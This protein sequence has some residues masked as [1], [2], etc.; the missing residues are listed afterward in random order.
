VVA[1]ARLRPIW[2]LV[3]MT[4]A[5]LIGWLT[6]GPVFWLVWRLAHR[7]AKA[8]ADVVA[9]A[10]VPG[11]QVVAAWYV[12]LAVAVLATLALT[13]NA[14]WL[15]VV[16]LLLL[17]TQLPTAADVAVAWRDGWRGRALVWRVRRWPAAR[18]AE[19]VRVAEALRQEWRTGPIAD[20]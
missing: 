4:P 10:F 8:R 1:E 3:L 18:R 11:L 9:R 5:A 2:A 16:V 19:I 17:V 7:Y 12:L 15:A 13:G 6:H 14:N 20:S